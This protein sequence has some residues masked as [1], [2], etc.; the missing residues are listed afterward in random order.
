MGANKCNVQ[1]I[2]CINWMQRQKIVTAEKKWG[3]LN[4]PLG[5]TLKSHATRLMT[6]QRKGRLILC[7]LQLMDL[8]VF[9]PVCWL[10]I[11]VASL[12]LKSHATRSNGHN[13]TAQETPDDLA[14]EDDGFSCIL[15][16]LQSS[17]P[18]SRFLIFPDIQ[19]SKNR[20]YWL[21]RTRLE[22]EKW[23]N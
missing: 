4:L 21:P 15:S 17:D 9:S 13:F 10:R 20:A 14:I 5:L 22:T 2:S 7:R 16:F 3:R 18:R 1:L 11:L 8:H 23:L 12:V 6:S 19:I